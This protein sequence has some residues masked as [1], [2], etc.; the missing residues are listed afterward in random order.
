MINFVKKLNQI[1]YNTNHYNNCDT[2]RLPKIVSSM[3]NVRLIYVFKNQH[4]NCSS[5]INFF[6][7]DL[8]L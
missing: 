1:S 5:S 2:N 3:S 4:L 7:T 6:L 8:R